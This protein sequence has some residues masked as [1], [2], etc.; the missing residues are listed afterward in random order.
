[1][2]K[3]FAKAFVDGLEKLLESAMVLI[4]IVMM[5][6]LMWQVFT[7]F[8]IKMPSIWTEEIARYSFLY[9]VMVGAAIGVK[10][11]THFGMTMLIEKMSSKTRYYYW[12]FVINVVI[13]VCSLLILIFGAE[14]TVKYGLTRVSP[15]FL[16]PMA[17]AFAII[18]VSALLMV[19]FA[20]YNILFGEHVPDPCE[21]NDGDSHV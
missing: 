9:M 2:V 16:V 7:R 6:S 15:T 18:P 14:F 5:G 1:M 8:V 12:R 13:L 10:R 19:V 11:S 20:V 3:N 4:L 17:W 21:C